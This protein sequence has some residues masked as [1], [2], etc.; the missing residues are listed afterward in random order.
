[1]PLLHV[2][3]EAINGRLLPKPRECPPWESV[4]RECLQQ[5]RWR[6]GQSFPVSCEEPAF[7]GLLGHK[8]LAVGCVQKHGHAVVSTH[9]ASLLCEHH[10]GGLETSVQLVERGGLHKS[11]VGVQQQHHSVIKVPGSVQLLDG[12]VEL[13][14][15]RLAIGCSTGKVDVSAHPAKVRTGF[16][17]AAEFSFPASRKLFHGSG[18]GQA[19]T[20]LSNVL[21]CPG[22][23][24]DAQI[25]S[26]R[27]AP[28]A[29]ARRQD[30]CGEELK[31]RLLL[32][33]AAHHNA[34]RDG[35]QIGPEAEHAA[36]ESHCG[37]EVAPVSG[38]QEQHRSA[39][40]HVAGTRHGVAAR[41]FGHSD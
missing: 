17:P 3:K 37:V 4:R 20:A 16:L 33:V 35:V 8:N 7:R 19:V 13:P 21:H 14:E 30:S 38:H 10:W 34:C 41:P 27:V 26:R 36:K 18:V 6:L 23:R 24:S 2:F 5:G 39:V 32:R 12:L 29:L 22:K 11:A 28:R 9:A 31:K 15:P 1:M 40:T 25:Q